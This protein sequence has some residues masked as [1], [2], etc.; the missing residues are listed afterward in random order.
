MYR[1]FAAPVQQLLG[2]CQRG[3]VA[4]VLRVEAVGGPKYGHVLSSNTAEAALRQPGGL[5]GRR[6]VDLPRFKN[7]RVRK[8]STGLDLSP[9]EEDAVLGQTVTA[10]TD[11]R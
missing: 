8:I 1:Y 2:Q 9:P 4:R 3:R 11:H 10:H 5:R 7:Q 6:I